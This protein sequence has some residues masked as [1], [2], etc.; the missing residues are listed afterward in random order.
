MAPESCSKQIY[1]L[2]NYRVEIGDHK[3][4]IRL[5]FRMKWAWPK[6]SVT[7]LGNLF[8]FGQLFKAFG[9]N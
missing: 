6:G 2:H 4:L 7:R 9:N 1:G 5:E 8:D 3:L